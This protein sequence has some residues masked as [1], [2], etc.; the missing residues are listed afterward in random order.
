MLG[1]WGSIESKIQS[2]ILSPLTQACPT[3][4]PLGSRLP[5]LLPSLSLQSGA[6]QS[7][8]KKEAAIHSSNVFVL[9]LI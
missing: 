7:L 3:L 6:R 4:L 2:W 8:A 5:Q 1:V 9:S